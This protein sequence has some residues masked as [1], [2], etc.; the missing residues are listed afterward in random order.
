MYDKQ[1]LLDYI[2]NR[3]V[4]VPELK[5][6][7]EKIVQD[8]NKA[9]MIGILHW[10]DVDMNYWGEK[11][12]ER[13]KYLEQLKKD[14]EEHILVE[15]SISRRCTF[16]KQAFLLVDE[17]KELNDWRF[18]Q[19]KQLVEEVKKQGGFFD[20]VKNP[21]LSTVMNLLQPFIGKSYRVEQAV[22]LLLSALQ[23]VI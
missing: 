1:L 15:S 3:Y 21:M 5:L 22:K 4:N 14:V 13:G 20:W 16:V 6:H 11:D 2:N 18:I 19:A 9:E 8:D 10:I 12:R 23:E 17:E 7:Y